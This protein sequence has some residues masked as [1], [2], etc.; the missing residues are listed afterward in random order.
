AVAGRRPGRAAV[1]QEGPHPSRSV[2]LPPVEGRRALRPVAATVAEGR[3]RPGAGHPRGGLPAM[4]AERNQP[5]RSDETQAMH[6]AAAQAGVA[7]SGPPA[8]TLEPPRLAQGGAADPGGA[9]ATGMFTADGATL[10]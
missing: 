10:A 1:E 2:V 4:S 7:A 9:D 5:G 8:P 6:V 3:R